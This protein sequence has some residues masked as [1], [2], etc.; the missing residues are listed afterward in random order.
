MANEN[1]RETTTS[2]PRFSIVTPTLNQVA[3]LSQT[4]ESVVGQAGAFSIEYRVIDGGSKDG[5]VDVL[6]DWEQR[7]AG[8]PKVRFSWMS[9]A[10]GGQAEA[11]NKGMRQARG[12]ILAFINS[13]DFYEPGIFQVVAD[14][15][16]RYP[17]RLWLSGYNRIV[18]PCGR[19]I[20]RPIF[21]YKN[22]WLHLNSPA[23]LRVLNY[24]SQPAT[25]FRRSAYEIIGPFD[26][27]LHLCMDYDYWL[28]LSKFSKP[29][30]LKRIVSN[31]RIH[32]GSKGKTAFC[33]QFDEE[34][35]VARR[36]GR[37]RTSIV[38]HKLHNDLI[39]AVYRYIKGSEDFDCQP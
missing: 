21:W 20:Q 18:D 6:R 23:V 26:E 35:R 33:D 22:F 34:L 3:Y 25:F 14:R 19:Q 28:R 12:D 30:I 39:K 2:M 32:P 4:I 7:L 16:D 27:G 10:D 15:F 29:I 8:H 1:V 11:I 37:G 13:D 38:L 5:T 31:F 17:D 9:E 24:I 36:Y